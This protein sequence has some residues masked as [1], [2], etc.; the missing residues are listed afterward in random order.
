MADRLTNLRNLGFRP[1]NILDVGAYVGRWT[2][3]TRRIF[4]EAKFLMV[5]A[6]ESKREL[7]NA[8]VAGARGQAQVDIAL[9]GSTPGEATFYEMETGSSMYPEMTA[10]PRTKVTKQRTTIDEVVARNGIEQID[11]AKLDVQGAELDVL[12]GGTKLLKTCEL[13]LLEASVAPYNEGAPLIADVVAFMSQKGF[14]LFDLCE[15]KRARST[16]FVLQV[17]LLFA[18]SDRDM[19]RGWSPA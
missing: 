2:E 10:V 19:S 6:Q 3:V 16:N 7:L 18:R 5:E 1:N 4:P 12:A 8:I 17:D 13:F 14:R 9:V 15:I 11:F